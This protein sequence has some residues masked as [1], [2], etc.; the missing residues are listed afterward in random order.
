MKVFGNYIWLFGEL[1]TELWYD[2]GAS[3]PFAPYP[4]GQIPYGIAAPFSAVIAGTGIAW[5]GTAASGGL[6]VLYASG[7]IPEVISSIPLQ[8]EF[9]KYGVVDDAVA[10]AYTD[11]GHTFYILNFP[12]RSKTW[13][14]DA[15]TGLWAERG[16]WNLIQSEFTVWRPRWHAWAFGQHRW[17]DH[18]VHSV[19]RTSSDV[20][21]DTDAYGSGTTESLY[22]RRLRRAPCVMNELDRLFFSSF[23]LDME[24]GLGIT[25]GQG[26]D[27]QVMLRFSDDG[28]KTWSNEMWRSAGKIGEYGKRIRWNRLGQARRRVFET[29]WS[30]PVP[31][32]LTAA[33]LE[34][35]QQ[36]RS[37][38]QSEAQ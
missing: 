2:T 14:W 32:R 31:Y 35:S 3:F 11:L 27:P 29:S 21:T 13:A 6:Y 38:R 34:F 24:P 30:E 15:T 20:S 17:L 9:S 28:G 37:T 1:T 25:V 36:P 16:S 5:L 26:E 8:Y 12:T 33:Y 22:L 18:S 4:S 19:Y 23:E 7:F 10:D